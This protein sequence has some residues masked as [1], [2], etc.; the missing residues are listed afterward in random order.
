ME[1]GL[2]KRV[3]IDHEMQQSY[4]DYAMSVIVS[5]ALP[6]ARDGLKPVQRRLLYAMYDMGIRPDSAYKKSAR[7]VGEVL[8]KYHPHGDQAVYESMARL[9]QDFSM[10]Y[11][12]ID[13]QGNFGSV[14]GDP[15][16]AMRYTEARIT[17]FALEL[18]NQLDRN[19]VNFDRNFDD[20]LSEPSVLPS[21]IPNMLVNGATGIA[22]GM[23]TSI[24]PHNLSETIDAINYMLEHW[25]KLD[26]ITVGDLMKYIKGPDFP[27]GGIILQE[28]ELNEL[29]ATYATGKGRITLRGRLNLEEMARGKSRII[30]TELPYMTNKSSL[31]ERIAELARE[32]DLEGVSDLRDESDRHGMRIV[33]EL[34]KAADADK[35]LR[36][37]Y[38][39]TPLQVT[40]SINLLA[41]VNGEPK[42]LSLKQALKVFVEH[43]L[44]IIKRRSEYDLKKAEDRIHIL[45]GLRI[46][47]KFLDEVIALIRSAADTDQAREKL[48][49]KFKLSIL[50]AQAILDMPLKRLA[51]LERKKIEQEYKDLLDLV[52]ELQSLLKSETKRRQAIITELVEI[53]A[54]YGDSRK[55][56]IVLLKQGKVAADLLTVKE[57][58]PVENVWIAI[59]KEGKIGKTAEKNPPRMGGR[60]APALLLKTDS[61]QNLYMVSKSGKCACVAVQSLHLVEDFENASDIH[62]VC[63]FKEGDSPVALFCL[64]HDQ[65][66]SESLCVTTL[67][68]Q[69]MIKKS[70]VS[71]LPGP[72]SDT[73]VLCKVNEGDELG[74]AM[75][76]ENETQ[77]L[78]LTNHGMSIRFEGDEVRIMG[79]VAAGVNALKLASGDQVAGMV[80]ITKGLE[81][82]AVS[83]DGKGW[84]MDEK[85]FPIQGR[86]G[87]GVNTC[88]IKPDCGMV[89]LTIG[90]K[91]TQI[92]LH[93]KKAAAKIIRLDEIPTGKRATSGKVVVELK[94]GDEVQ[95]LVAI[96]DNVALPV[97]TDKLVQKSLL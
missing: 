47:I 33:I 27:T 26:E 55:T 42:L 30:V 54:K 46:A 96:L 94:P 28:H 67:T 95:G 6:D 49:K 39:R 84:R 16:A 22:V 62:R 15:P 1:L 72:S 13:G 10:R 85:E 48:M 4:L 50:Q 80:E 20:T 64:S 17:P 69:G 78:I 34:N 91:N 57:V 79:L 61:H 19:T 37:L 89:G 70:L 63:S 45:E 76:N 38:K 71:E 53:K 51:S 14:D 52:K 2:V 11:E 82:F 73:F 60:E 3:D 59:S 66:H 35:T 44:E 83:S 23:A 87:Q 29:Q 58:T 43:R 90:K 24:P 25:Q 36:A 88:K 9:A 5:R 86:Y 93:L 8:G 97:G 21:A 65:K 41:L 32:G 74:W 40:Y 18:L 7:I 92:A 68:K 56:Q 12:L 81:L 31:I 77:Y 75:L